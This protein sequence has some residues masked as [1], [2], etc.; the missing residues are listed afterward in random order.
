MKFNVKRL[1][2]KISVSAYGYG[3]R[4]KTVIEGRNLFIRYG[5]RNRSPRD[6]TF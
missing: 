6:I 2:V 1:S 3:V 4:P 5:P